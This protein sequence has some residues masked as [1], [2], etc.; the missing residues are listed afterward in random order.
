MAAQIRTLQ[1]QVKTLQ[2]TLKTPEVFGEPTGDLLIV[3]WGSSR[4]A[5]EEAVARARK[6]GLA[7]SSLNIKYIQPMASG[8][9]EILARFRQVM[10]IESAFCDNPEDEL[11]DAESRR[12]APLCTIL[13]T[14]FA[15][16]IDSWGQ[17]NGQSIKPGTILQI[18][19]RKIS[20]GVTR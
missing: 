13:R 18:I 16:D 8:I 1:K 10:T 5:I 17:A 14:R 11:I 9:R 20:E 19:R 4:G 7:V 2:K 15:R 6:E 12:Y 3:G